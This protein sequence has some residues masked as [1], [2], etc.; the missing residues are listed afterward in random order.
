MIENRPFFA[1]DSC[2]VAVSSVAKKSS[3]EEVAVAPIS[4][5]ISPPH[6]MHVTNDGKNEHVVKT[7]SST[8][9]HAVSE[10]QVHVIL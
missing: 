3:F 10:P 2:R 8:C 4:G 6:R 9:Q 5:H 1:Y 7:V